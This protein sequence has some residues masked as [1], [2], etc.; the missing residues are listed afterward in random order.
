MTSQL[1]KK[2]ASDLLPRATHCIYILKHQPMYRRAGFVAKQHTRIHLH[3]HW[4][5]HTDTHTHTRSD[6]HVYTRTRSASSSLLRVLGCR[7]TARAWMSVP[8]PKT[9]SP[10]HVPA[11]V[12]RATAWARNED[13]ADTRAD[14]AHFHTNTRIHGHARK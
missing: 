9:A 11:S 10:S 4:C 2:P 6:T 5:T 12:P 3:T 8:V 1:T 13:E 7:R 14:H